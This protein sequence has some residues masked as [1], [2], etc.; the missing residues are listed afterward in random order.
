MV[1]SRKQVFSLFVNK[2]EEGSGKKLTEAAQV[3]PSIL[4]KSNKKFYKTQRL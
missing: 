4:Y 3:Q 2:A 1:V